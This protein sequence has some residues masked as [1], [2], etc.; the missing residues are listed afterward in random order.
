MTFYNRLKTHLKHGY[1]Y[2][3]KDITLNQFTILIRLSQ[4]FIL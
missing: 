1:Y 4:Q 2:V 3:F